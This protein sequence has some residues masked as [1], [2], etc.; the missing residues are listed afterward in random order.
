M[1][2]AKTKGKI[3]VEALKLFNEKGFV[4]VRLQHIADKCNICVGN[5]AYHFESGNL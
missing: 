5:L 4:N 2:V 3:L 1:I